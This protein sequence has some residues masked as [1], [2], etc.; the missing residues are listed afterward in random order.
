[1]GVHRCNECSY[2][3]ERM[4]NLKVHQKR[5]HKH[6]GE[7]GIS[8]GRIGHAGVVYQNNIQPSGNA[9]VQQPSN[10]IDILAY[11]KLL[12]KQKDEYNYKLELGKITSKILQKGEIRPDHLTN[13]QKE[14]LQLY[15]RER[16]SRKNTEKK[17]RPK[18]N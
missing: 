3:T 5:K 17:Q 10:S 6:M 7:N 13:D 18:E 2:Q 14:A 1:M 15:R 4:Y 11:E 16:K 8:T 12:F 9:G